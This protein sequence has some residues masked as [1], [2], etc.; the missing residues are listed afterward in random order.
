LTLSSFRKANRGGRSEKGAFSHP[1]RQR[2]FIL[3]HTPLS[4]VTDEEVEAI[5]EVEVSL[6]E[7]PARVGLGTEATWHAG[8]REVDCSYDPLISMADAAAA[9]LALDSEI[10]WIKR[11]VYD[12]N[13]GLLGG[14]M[15]R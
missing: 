1:S 2:A 12:T 15:E 5:A 4:A 6:E 11:Y 14:A 10:D 13:R 9:A 7:G 8:P 3:L